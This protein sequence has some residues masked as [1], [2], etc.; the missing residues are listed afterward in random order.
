MLPEHALLTIGLSAAFADGRNDPREREHLLRF[1]EG[2]GEVVPDLPRLYQDVLLK[3]VQLSEACASLGDPGQRALALELAVGVCDSDGQRTEAEQHFLDELEGLLGLRPTEPSSTPAV[4]VFP[5]TRAVVA[6]PTPR[7][8]PTHP[9]PAVDEAALDQRIL[10]SSILNG[11]LELLPQSW[12]SMAIIPLQMRLVYTVGRAYGYEL[13]Q[14]HLKEFVATAGVGLTSQYLE[15]FGRKLI[16][17]LLG[18]GLGRTLGGVGRSATGMAFS[19]ASTYALGHLAKRYYR[20]GRQLGPDGLKAEFQRLLT[21]ARA[22]QAQVL[23]QIQARAST[24]T[25]TE[26]MNL[27]RGGQTV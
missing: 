4:P 25:P 26:V 15:Q 23:P 22:L 2:L 3:R 11:A 20:D 1:A 8:P 5:E 14:G 27:V 13:D 18:A 24:L 12:A 10:T 16:G 21:P 6:A 9:A 17:G 19:F 7:V